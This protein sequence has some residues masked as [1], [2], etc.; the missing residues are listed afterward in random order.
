MA[1]VSHASVLSNMHDLPRSTLRWKH[2]WARVRNGFTPGLPLAAWT[3]PAPL[4]WLHLWI[5]P[6][7][8]ALTWPTARR[9]NSRCLQAPLRFY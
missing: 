9:D 5:Q 4:L 2:V 1:G 8:K 3:K 6:T 7:K